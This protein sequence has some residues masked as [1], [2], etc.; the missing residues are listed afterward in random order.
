MLLSS[1]KTSDFGKVHQDIRLLIQDFREVLEG[2]GEQAIA[3]ALPWQDTEAVTTRPDTTKMV[4]ALSIAFQLL[5]SVEENAVVQYRR[6]LEAQDEASHLSGLWNQTL[7]YLKGKGLTEE[8]VLAELTQIRVEPVLTAHPT[9]AKRFSV[10]EQHRSLYLSLVDLENQMWTPHEQRD[11]RDQ[12]KVG[13]ERLWRTGEIYLDKPDV[14]SEVR[15]VIY[16]LSKVF[17]HVIEPLDRRLQSAWIEAGFDHSRSPQ[18]EHLPRLS[19]ATWVGGDRD[20]HPLVTAEVTRSTLQGLR[21]HG[22]ELLRNRLTSLAQQLSL[23]DLL[24]TPPASLIGRLNALVKLL[25]ADARPALDRNPDEPWRQYVNLLVTRLPASSQQAPTGYTYRL[26]GELE[27]DLHVLYDSLLGLGAARIAN[28]D[29]LPVIRLAQIF[30]FHLAA[31]DIRQNSR[32]HDLAMAQL[33]TAAG[34]DGD[35]FPTWDEERRLAFLE[36]ELNTCRPFTLPGMQLG[37]EA[38]AVVSCYR[39]L[40][41]YIDQY[42]T[43]GLGSLIIS[44]TRSVSDLLVVYLLAREGG[45]VVNAPDGLVCKLPLVPLFET[46]D[47]LERSPSILER[48][49]A[50]PITQRSLAHQSPGGERVQQVMIG[51]S[52]SNKDGG[53]FSSLWQLYVAQRALTEVGAAHDTHIRFFHGRGGSISRGAGPSHRFIRAIPID[54][55]H[56]DLRLTEQGEIIARKY[57]NRLTAM[58]NLEL[59]LSEVTRSSAQQRYLG[60]PQ[61]PELDALMPQL[62]EASYRA[63]RQLLETPGFIEFYRQATPIDVIE[64]SRIGSRPTRRTGQHTLADLRAI[65]W[66][67]SWSQSR[68]F[69]SGWYG[70]GTALDELRQHNPNQFAALKARAF[71]WPQF[72]YLIS[73]VASNIMLADPRLMQRYAELVHDDE[74]RATIMDQILDELTR[75]RSVIEAIYGGALAER[76]PNVQQMIDLRREPLEYLHDRQVALLREW[77]EIPA[78]DSDAEQ[79]LTK[80]LLLT[81]AIANG[82]GTTG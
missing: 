31:L 72:H 40:A 29:V 8:Q 69:L 4:Q 37:P 51:Y 9:E 36:A 33:L 21:E 59:F 63:Y 45:L 15:N 24:Q 32:F 42:G 73:S 26:A 60:R 46:I 11:I 65:P 1:S 23:S 41:D 66:V 79:L 35:D 12:I 2:L 27:Q 58:H 39:V 16:Y 25:G 71:D 14:A 57:A 52:D 22:L 78:G 76:R 34:L 20:G 55:L 19:F 6:Q 28:A 43:A 64:S 13:L 18:I 75:T 30:G 17:P 53:I 47:D 5:N 10:L 48:F 67:F 49:L 81:N 68:F 7:H 82:L 56:G 61:Q 54:A 50:Y 62:A 70:V 74:L 80:L 38:E 44:M 77:R 3:D